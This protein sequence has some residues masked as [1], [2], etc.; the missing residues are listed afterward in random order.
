[1]A[2]RNSPMMTPTRH[3]PILTFMLLMIFGI[4][5]GII[6][7]FSISLRLPPRVRIRSSLSGSVWIKL[8]VR[9]MTVLKIAR[10]TA[11]TMMV[12]MLL[13]SHTMK[14]GAN[15]VFGRLFKVIR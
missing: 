8:V 11:Q 15:A 3:R 14:M 12:F 4:L 7:F 1:M 5:P 2:E 10:D 9:L 13:P 6:T